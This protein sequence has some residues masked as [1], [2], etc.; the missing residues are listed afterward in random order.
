MECNDKQQTKKC[1]GI[2]TSSHLSV[3]H[4][5]R[6][7]VADDRA[8][9]AQCRPTIEYKWDVSPS[10][11]LVSIGYRRSSKLGRFGRFGFGALFPPSC[12]RCREFA[13]LHPIRF[14]GITW[15]VMATKVQ[16]TLYEFLLAS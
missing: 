7:A 6:A 10:S 13:R 3:Y 1:K 9:A 11:Q 14:D 16:K 15:F 2:N 5:C 8:V 12:G 4:S